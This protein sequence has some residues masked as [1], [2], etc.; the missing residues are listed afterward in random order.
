MMLTVAEFVAC[1]LAF[2]V[3]DPMILRSNMPAMD[4]G[5]FQVGQVDNDGTAIHLTYLLICAWVFI[6]RNLQSIGYH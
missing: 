3:S 2:D 4:S 5:G 1:S 6:L